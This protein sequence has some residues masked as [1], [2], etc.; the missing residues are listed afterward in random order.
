[1]SELPQKRFLR[2]GEV[3]DFLGV[4]D[5]VMTQL[6]AARQLSPVYLAGAKGRAF[7]CREDVLKLAAN[8]V[9]R[10]TK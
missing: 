4:T 7:F 6:L 10:E 2:R 9:E 8:K 5:H 3:R 1:M